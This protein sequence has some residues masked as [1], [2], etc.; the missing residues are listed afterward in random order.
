MNYFSLL[1]CLST[2]EIKTKENQFPR[3]HGSSSRSI[4][5]IEL[6]A[7][8][9]LQAAEATEYDEKARPRD[10]PARF[11]FAN[12]TNI[13]LKA[14]RRDRTRAVVAPNGRQAA[15]PPRLLKTSGAARVCAGPM[16]RH[17]R[18][19]YYPRFACYGFFLPV[20]FKNPCGISHAER[21]SL[22]KGTSTSWGRESLWTIR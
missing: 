5:M 4:L 20:S 1:E 16:M 7:W 3:S 6:C 10:L 9:I 14:T 19:C 2:N 15:R 11:P 17:Y 22:P 21:P 18:T 8:Y 12:S 13:A